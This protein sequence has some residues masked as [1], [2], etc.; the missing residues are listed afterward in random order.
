M[1]SNRL[2]VR[3]DSQLLETEEF[4]SG[5]D[6]QELD[7]EKAAP[8]IS[9]KKSIRNLEISSLKEKLYSLAC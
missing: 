6:L 4:G 2:T 8:L 7:Q 1:W 3:H 5:K 9:L